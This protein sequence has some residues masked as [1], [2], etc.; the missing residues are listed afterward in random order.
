[1][2]RIATIWLAL[3]MLAI[4]EPIL[5]QKG[6]Q[7]ILNSLYNSKDPDKVKASIEQLS[8]LAQ[9]KSK[10]KEYILYQTLLGDQYLRTNDFSKAEHS[11]AE[12]YQVAKKNMPVKR[13]GRFKLPMFLNFQL[14]IFD[15]I[16]RLGYYYLKIGNLRTA[17]QYFTESKA[18]RDALVGKRSIHR[19]HPLIGMGSLS[20]RRG[21]IEQTY[22]QFNEAEREINRSMS[23]AYDYDILNRLYLNDL[24]E[25][26]LTLSKMDEA[27]YYINK[28]ALA[29]SGTRKFT[30]KTIARSETARVLEMKARYYLMLKDYDKA[31]DYLDRADYYQPAKS[32]SDVKFKLL[33]TRG[34]LEWYQGHS[35]EAAKAFSGLVQA[36]REYIAQNFVAMSDYE[37]EQFYASLKKDFDLFNAFV[38]DQ[39]NSASAVMLAEN[40]YDNALN[41]K[42][43]LLNES[44]RQK[45]NILE[46]GNPELI[47]MLKKWEYSKAAL[48]AS[49]YEETDPRKI[50]ELE[51]TIDDLE[52]KLNAASGLFSGSL[53]A[54]SW[55]DVKAN[56]QQ[57]E[58]SVELIRVR[59]ADKSRA[60]MVG[61]SVVYAVLLLRESSA[62]PQLFMVANGNQLEKR[63]LAYYR[64]AIMSRLEDSN[65]Y[66]QFWQPIRRELTGINKLYISPDG[67]YNQI[68]L[69]T[70]QN[71]ATKNYLIDETDLVY[72]TNS[73]DLLKKKAEVSPEKL[74]VLIGRPSYDFEESAMS[75]ASNAV[76]GQRNV[77]SEELQSFKEQEFEDLPGTETEIKVIEPILEQHA[78]TVKAYKG[79]TALEENVKAVHHPSVL[80][81]ATHGFFVDDAASAV[82]PM[83]RSGIVLAGVRNSGHATEQEDGILTAYEATNLDLEGTQLVVLSA[84]QTGL[85][86]VRNGE[87]VYGLQRAIVVA[88][89][90]NL[91]MS[92]WKV[93]DAATADLMTTFYKS[94]TG[95]DN[96]RE[97]REAQRALRKKYPQP[98]YWGAFVMLGK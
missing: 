80:H 57:K 75:G 58:A 24:A 14:T 65:S 19:V 59:L 2:K 34:M 5:A 38:L 53:N 93:D 22:Q 35:D 10:P 79:E 20:Y 29:S 98:F 50:D 30:T 12:A 55:K 90:Q 9:S 8:A 62:S 81:I 87:G 78:L 74:A 44:N 66:D 67:V 37:K 68:N 31:R 54:L 15:P 82:N 83:I 64:N 69:N 86:E 49:Y 4:H 7:R 95:T 97:F 89:A 77:I 27:D 46:S 17:E 70:L 42:A 71:P 84:C 91:I 39:Q 45:N 85:G 26:C 25:I 33:K 96:T 51:K 6:K 11:Y 23:S 61:D 21:L 48:S 28:L 63:Y 41:T 32:V 94:W 47:D 43:L 92:L 88:G 52:K 3:L 36:Y 40:M 73:S 60:G 1:M 18:L 72:L 13:N 16:D 76:Y 56:L